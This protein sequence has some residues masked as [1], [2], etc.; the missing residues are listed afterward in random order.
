MNQ[1]GFILQFTTVLA[2]LIF[3]G[4]NAQAQTI[5][6]TIVMGGGVTFFQ[7]TKV[8]SDD[9]NSGEDVT[10]KQEVLA[11]LGYIVKDDILLGLGIGYY[12]D[13]RDYQSPFYNSSNSKANG[14]IIN[15]HIRY[16][17]HTSN[18]DFVFFVDGGYK[19]KKGNLRNTSTLGNETDWKQTTWSISIRPGLGY[20]F[21]K[22]VGV[23]LGFNGISYTKEDPNR[24]VENNEVKTLDLG[25]N[26]LLPSTIGFRI[27]F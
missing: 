23:E 15:P 20:F 7:Q 11:S 1:N 3:F 12:S 26:S 5:S 9:G 4:F 18:E 13:E 16:Y 10:T 27:Y 22:N 24:D 6:K 21:S 17:L 2:S 14:Y 19:L 8:L 25:L